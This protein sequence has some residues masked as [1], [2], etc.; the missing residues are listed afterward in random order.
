MAQV[1]LGQA[2]NG[3]CTPP[4]VAQPGNGVCDQFGASCRMWECPD[5][6]DVGNN[7]WAFKWSD[8]V[9]FSLY[10]ASQ[11]VAQLNRLSQQVLSLPHAS[12]PARTWH[13]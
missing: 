4:A 1:M 5:A 11:K 6:F 8:Q 12:A 3:Q 7:T 13:H 10:V 2:T 9:S